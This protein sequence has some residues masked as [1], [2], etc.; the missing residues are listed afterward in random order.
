MLP[1]FLFNCFSTI[2]LYTLLGCHYQVAAVVWVVDLAILRKFDAAWAHNSS[3]NT[4][5]NE[6]ENDE[7]TAVGLSAL[8]RLLEA[9]DDTVPLEIVVRT[10]LV[11]M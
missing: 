1:L 6:S 8:M 3:N 7:T 11:T 10:L 4:K 5:E 2:P 9:V